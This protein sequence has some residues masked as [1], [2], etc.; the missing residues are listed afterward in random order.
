MEFLKKHWPTLSLL[1]G[2]LLAEGLIYLVAFPEESRQL[3]ENEDLLDAITGAL[4]ALVW[5]LVLYLCALVCAALAF[6]FAIKR[7]ES[8]RDIPSIFVTAS[9]FLALIVIVIQAIA[10]IWQ[11]L[12]WITDLPGSLA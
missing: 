3:A 9:A 7:M 2:F 8:D 5:I 4:G 12:A 6:R 1:G 11:N 10:T